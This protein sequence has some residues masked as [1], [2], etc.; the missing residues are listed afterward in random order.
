LQ[1][2][3]SVVQ[4][5][6]VLILFIYQRVFDFQAVMFQVHVF[7]VVMQCSVM[8]G[9]RRFGGPCCLHLQ[10]DDLQVALFWVVTICSIVVGYQRFGGPCCLHL[11]HAITLC[12]NSED[13]NPNIRRRENL[14]FR[15]TPYNCSFYFVTSV[16][17][18]ALS[19]NIGNLQILT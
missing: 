7:C 5:V 16:Q 4:F 14:K 18:C 12:H 17:N 10:R 6:T 3:S 11:Y 1:L 8:V 15:E 2:S 9:Y 19:L 13:H